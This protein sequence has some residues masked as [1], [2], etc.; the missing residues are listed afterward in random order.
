[1]NSAAESSDLQALPGNR[2]VALPG[3]GKGQYSIRLN[4]QWPRI[5][6]ALDLHVPVARMA[7]HQKA[8]KFS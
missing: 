5:H 2:L 6:P 1:L 8:Q 4:D 7:V 3:D